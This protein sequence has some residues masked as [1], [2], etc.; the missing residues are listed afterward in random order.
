EDAQFAKRL[1]TLLD[2][3][4]T[5]FIVVSSRAASIHYDAVNDM[6]SRIKSDKSLFASGNIR[7]EAETGSQQSPFLSS[8]H[9]SDHVLDFS[10]GTSFGDLELDNKVYNTDFLKRVVDFCVDHNLNQSIQIALIG[11]IWAEEYPVSKE[12]VLSTSFPTENAAI[13]RYRNN[14]DVLESTISAV[15]DGVQALE[16]IGNQELLHDWWVY[17]IGTL[18]SPYYQLVP[19]V[20]EK[21]W[22]KLVIF[23]GKVYRS[24]EDDGVFD[25]IGLHDR[26][27]IYLIKEKNRADCEAVSVGRSDLGSKYSIDVVDG[28]PLS[29]P[30]YLGDLNTTV[31]EKILQC[32]NWELQVKAGILDYRWTGP[33][34]LR[35][36]GYAYIEGLDA[37]GNRNRTYIRVID[38]FTGATIER[39]VNR[40]NIPRV[41]L[42]SN[43]RNLSYSSSGFEVDLKVSELPS[44][45]EGASLGSNT[46]KIEAYVENQGVYAQG[47]FEWRDR[48]GAA[49]HLNLAEIQSGARLVPRFSSLEGLEV[50]LDQPRYI[51]DEIDLDG[52]DLKLK[53]RAPGNAIPVEIEAFCT[54]T[55]TKVRGTLSDYNGNA[56]AFIVHLPSV[57]SDARAK[58]EWELSIR[59]KTSGG[60]S[61]PLAWA[62]DESA[63]E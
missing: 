30:N 33:T 23:I 8:T 28:N 46:W 10:D 54:V 45:R 20:G 29:A 62:Y 56:A 41:D 11:S 16:V 1:Q 25:E 43:D 26:I 19:R 50:K 18:M 6:V 32:R 3:V 57:T 39:P 60:E 48:S 9:K 40:V 2:H 12:V 49:A 35:I 38:T 47:P 36:T 53:V 59:A 5:D 51:V 42:L 52:R 17:S 63:L 4:T 31:P 15:E 37:S 22:E 7:H 21:F 58:G 27:L 24:I 44:Q 34:T 13:R 61:Y 55:K 14:V